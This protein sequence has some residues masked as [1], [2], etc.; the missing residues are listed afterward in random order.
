MYK[1][2]SE[3]SNSEKMK[4]S[5]TKSYFG[6]YQLRDVTDED[7]KK[8]QH[9]RSKKDLTLEN[10]A[11]EFGLIKNF[12]SYTLLLDNKGKLHI[13]YL[14]RTPTDKQRELLKTILLSQFRIGL[15]QG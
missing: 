14:D 4:L 12:P 1:T 2:Y 9:K 3:L 10:I 5:K 11:M 8:I 6:G 13:L 15:R 7:L